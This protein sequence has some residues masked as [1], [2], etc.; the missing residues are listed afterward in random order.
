MR[1]ILFA[2]TLHS[3]DLTGLLDVLLSD[4]KPMVIA[5]AIVSLS[6]VSE[7]IT[8]NQVT[9]EIAL[10]AHFCYAVVDVDL[11]RQYDALA[12]TF[13]K[14]MSSA[15]CHFASFVSNSSGQSYG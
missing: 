2:G 11:S 7:R 4:M 15:C 10:T 9:I 6:E 12:Q 14:A 13:P 1:L 8:T 5:S 3:Q